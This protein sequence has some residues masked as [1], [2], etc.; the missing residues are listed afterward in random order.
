LS[1]LRARADAAAQ[2]F[3]GD[4]AAVV[5]D[6]ADRHHLV[7]VL[8]L[9]PGERVVACDGAGSWRLCALTGDGCLDPAGEVAT[10]PAPA[11][12]VAV[13]L[14]ALKGDRAEWA[15]AKLTE[16]G[17][18]EIGLLR[19]ERASVRLDAATVDRVLA[20]WRRVARE[21]ACQ[22]RRT[23]LPTILGP[24]DVEAALSA[25]A[26][27]CDLEGAAQVAA[28]RSLVVG[29]EGGWSEAERGSSETSF[30]LA[31]GVL[32]TETAAVVAGV[33]VTASR[34]GTP[35]AARAEAQ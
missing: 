5:L 19:C 34:G 17:V 18:D 4:L 1:S 8:R 33:V 28:P 7:R 26:L 14:P 6:E 13:W 30:G 12:D 25:G 32:R 15:I 31:D 27:R 24:L 29:P 10:E 9:R 23:R 21:A 11:A 3:V 22:S 35:H 16:L 2:V 20:R